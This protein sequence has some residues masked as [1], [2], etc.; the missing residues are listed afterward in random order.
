MKE[1]GPALQVDF[2]SIFFTFI[3][4]RKLHSVL[5]QNKNRS[6]D[7]QDHF[8]IRHWKNAVIVYGN[9]LWTMYRFCDFFCHNVV[10]TISHITSR[11]KSSIYFGSTLFSKSLYHWWA[12]VT[13]MYQQYCTVHQ[14]L[15]T[16]M[17]YCPR[18]SVQSASLQRSCDNTVQM[19]LEVHQEWKYRLCRPTLFIASLIT[20]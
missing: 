18:C 3:S 19:T 14:E 2:L 20:V 7:D 11:T 4:Y 10:R 12:S 5:K 13:L 1:I 6:A 16:G 15:H 17:Q 8:C 9:L